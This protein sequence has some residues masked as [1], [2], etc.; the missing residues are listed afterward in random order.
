[1]TDFNNNAFT[2]GLP[3]GKR[4]GMEEEVGA[5]PI[6]A[7]CDKLEEKIGFYFFFIVI[8]LAVDIVLLDFYHRIGLELGLFRDS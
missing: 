4:E 1:M 3:L 6:E 7:G 8:A 5:F 2:V